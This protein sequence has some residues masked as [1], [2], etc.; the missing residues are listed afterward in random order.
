MNTIISKVAHDYSI[1]PKALKR[2][3]KASGLKT[4]KVSRLEVLEVVYISAPELFYCRADE[5]KGTVEYLDINLNIKLCYE[6]KLLKKLDE[7][8]L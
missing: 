3:L 8:L 5:E 4:K 7:V 6:I 2:H 1:N